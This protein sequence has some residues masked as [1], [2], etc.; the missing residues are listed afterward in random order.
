MRSGV[1]ST[2]LHDLPAYNLGTAVHGIK[3]TS[4][5]QLWCGLYLSKRWDLNSLYLARVITVAGGLIGVR[6]TSMSHFGADLE[7]DIEEGCRCMP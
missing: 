6:T 7:M 5:S 3:N 4:S 2:Q 1:D